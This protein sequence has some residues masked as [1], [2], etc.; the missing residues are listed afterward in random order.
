MW[1]THLLTLSLPGTAISSLF[2]IV[3]W[4]L[5]LAFCLLGHVGM[6]GPECQTLRWEPWEYADGHTQMYIAPHLWLGSYRPLGPVASL[7][8]KLSKSFSLLVVFE[9][10]SG[11]WKG[12]PGGTS[13]KEPTCQCRKHQRCGFDPWVGTIPWRKAWQCTPVFLPRE[14]P[15]QRSL[16]GYSPWVPKSWTRLKWFS[17]PAGFERVPFFALFGKISCI[18]ERASLVAQ[19]GKNLPEMWETW[20]GKIPWRKE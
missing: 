11:S 1:D 2:P 5:G 4:E 12:F 20:V 3:S 6:F 15:G 7:W 17:I 10:G 8:G 16:V 18:R 13:S 9:R 19:M 14:S